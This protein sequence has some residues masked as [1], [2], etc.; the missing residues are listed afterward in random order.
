MDLDGEDRRWSESGWVGLGG[1]EVIVRD[2]LPPSEQIDGCLSLSF[3]LIEEKKLRHWIDNFYGYGSWHAD[4]WLIALEESGGEVPE[5]V[6]EKV[7]YFE[8]LHKATGE[9]TLCDI[10]DL[11]Q[12]VSVLLD[13]PRANLFTSRYEYRFGPH[14]MLHGVWK[15][16][17]A[18]G[19][20]YRN[21]KLSD[22]L[23]YQ[24]NIFIS[25]TSRNEALISLY[26]LPGPHSHSWYYSWLDLPNLP[27][28]KSRQSYEDHVYAR[29]LQSILSNIRKHKP[30]VV[31]MY[32]M[33]NIQ[34][35]KE[36]V[37]ESF[38][39][40]QFKMIKAT[41]QK[42]PQ[43]HRASLHETTLLIT[44]QIPALRHNRIET[45]FDWEEFGKKVRSEAAD[46]AAE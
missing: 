17:I 42:I 37:Q 11:Y 8:R 14:A 4:V 30:G 10:R 32:G 6:A 2:A 21:N 45:G 41:K 39:G 16:L 35:L 38:E 1:E 25:P 44:T 5:E 46:E 43:H 9:P 29:R 27:F 13:G 40:V 7:N 15:N 18:F 12:H 34:T 19:H 31:L 33:N 20:G 3:M 28:L 26:P 22:P 24:K 23:E 36:S